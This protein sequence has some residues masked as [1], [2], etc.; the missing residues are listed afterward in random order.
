MSLASLHTYL[1][2]ECLFDPFMWEDPEWRNHPVISG[3]EDTCTDIHLMQRYREALRLP[4]T[5]FFNHLWV[6]AKGDTIPEAKM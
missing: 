2:P 1:R 3:D 5:V 4:H 6:K